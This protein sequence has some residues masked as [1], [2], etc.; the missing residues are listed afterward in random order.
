M[1]L[2]L[3]K[4]SIYMMLILQNAEYQ[5]ILRIDDNAKT[6]I[7]SQFEKQVVDDIVKCFKQEGK[8]FQA[9]EHD[10]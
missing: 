7:V 2:F 10:D 1:N 8:I 9:V 3:L 6:D 4:V 5:A